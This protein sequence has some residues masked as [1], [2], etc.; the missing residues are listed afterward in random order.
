M[1]PECHRFICEEGCPAYRGRSAERG[2]ALCNCSLCDT[3]IARGESF[4][5]VG[6]RPV[7]RECL[8]DS[9]AGDLTRLFGF[10]SR[11]A[12]LLALGASLRHGGGNCL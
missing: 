8:E 12:L 2:R 5:S 6:A 10:A 1:C 9:D 11:E 3:P 7:C 4:Y